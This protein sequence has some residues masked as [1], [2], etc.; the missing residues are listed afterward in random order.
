MPNRF[1]HSLLSILSPLV[2]LLVALGLCRV[3]RAAETTE[4]RDFSAEFGDYTGCFALYDAAQQH[5]VRFHPDECKVRT[6]PCS[7][8]KIPNSLIALETG[9]ASGPEF[10]LP[11]DGK[12]HTIEAWN[13]DQ[14]LRSAFS[15]SCVWYYQALATR[16]G[17]ERYREILPKMRYGNND[18]SGGVTEFWLQTSLTIS[19]DEQVDFLRR[20]HARELPFS[21][22]TVETVLDIMTLARNG[23]SV[24]RGKT[25][26]AGNAAG[27]ATMG[28]FVGSVST[29]K[30]DYFF[31]A[32]IA[33]GEKPLGFKARGIAEKILGELGIWTAPEE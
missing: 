32:R 17:I 16:I 10:P 5:W 3:A 7:T 8:F 13:Q 11:W 31:A 28:W 15:V 4:E 21:K 30:G 18:V 29:P 9:V 20:M 27:E 25:G 24:F 23:E 19:P 1:R 6:S 14:T 22:K 26:T 12:K 33:G 2:L